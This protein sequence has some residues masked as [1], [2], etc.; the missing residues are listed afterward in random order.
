MF[1]IY[2]KGSRNNVMHLLCG[3]LNTEYSYNWKACKRTRITCVRYVCVCVRAP[4]DIKPDK[5]DNINV[6]EIY[7]N[8]YGRKNVIR[9][10]YTCLHFNSANF[11]ISL[12]A[13]GIHSTWYHQHFFFFSSF[14]SLRFILSLFNIKQSFG[15]RNTQIN[16]IWVCGA[17]SSFHSYSLRNL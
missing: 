1:G 3:N 7:H 6:Q 16:D 17:H 5:F 12:T 13:Y 9:K 8:G 11:N 14:H 10:A 15:T 2:L 4:C